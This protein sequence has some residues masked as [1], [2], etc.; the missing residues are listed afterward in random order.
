[1]GDAME[2][3]AIEQ[4]LSK[5]GS[6]ISCKINTN[7]KGEIE[8]L[9]IISDT[10]RSCKQISRDIQSILVSKFDIDLDYKKISIAQVDEDS[11]NNHRGFRLRL[12][13]IEY[14]TSGT[15]ID[16]KVVL[17]K[18]ETS[19]EGCVSG[20]N[21]S[22]NSLRILANATLKAIENF[23]GISDIYI[24]ED[25]ADIDLARSQAVIAAVTFVTQE[26]EQLFSGSA[27]V[28]RDKKEAIVKA[29]LDAVN[30]SISKH[31]AN[32]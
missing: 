17:E 32:I 7:D 29:T 15:K 26:K 10:N 5:I 1:V 3:K 16:V 6:V 14:N 30:R 2:I 9:H 27:F 13:N 12:K 18:G 28:N 25:I 24:L 11:L 19:Y 22:F 4:Y 21:T 20:P 8:E 31:F 23:T